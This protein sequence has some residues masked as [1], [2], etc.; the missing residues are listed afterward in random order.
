[1]ALGA[2]ENPAQPAA[3]NMPVVSSYMGR[4]LLRACPGRFLFMVVKASSRTP[5]S[6]SF[7]G[8][9]RRSLF[10][11]HQGTFGLTVRGF[12]PQFSVPCLSGAV[13]GRFGYCA[14]TNI[15]LAEQNLLRREL[16]EVAS[17]TCQTC[18]DRENKIDKSAASTLGSCPRCRANSCLLFFAYASCA[19]FLYWGVDFGFFCPPFKHFYGSWWQ[20]VSCGNGEF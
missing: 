13:F 3:S 8:P 20:V 4:S 19:A 7:G 14:D 1:M 16:Y 5:V 12:V 2:A 18:L 11:L 6:G 9:C 15:R 10:R 17:K